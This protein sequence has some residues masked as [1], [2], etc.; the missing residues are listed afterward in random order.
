VVRRVVL[1][2]LLVVLVQALAPVQVH[3]VECLAYCPALVKLQVVCG[4]LHVR[5]SAAAVNVTRRPKKAR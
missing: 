2:L 4:R 1:A 3:R 5:D